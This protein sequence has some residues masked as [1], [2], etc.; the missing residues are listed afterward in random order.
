MIKTVSRTSYIIYG[1]EMCFN[2]ELEVRSKPRCVFV[3][4]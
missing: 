2:E 1:T 3:A 4:L